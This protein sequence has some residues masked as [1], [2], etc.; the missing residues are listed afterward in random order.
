MTKPLE[1]ETVITLSASEA[2]ILGSWLD[3]QA[4]TMRD[5]KT[6]L[7]HH[8]LGD[9]VFLLSALMKVSDALLLG[10]AELLPAKG[11]KP[12]PFTPNDGIGHN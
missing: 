7:E 10:V 8:T 1:L 2:A 6:P 5:R 11:T 3:G 12:E 9:M 4:D